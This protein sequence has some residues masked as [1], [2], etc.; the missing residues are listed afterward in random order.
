MKYALLMLALLPFLVKAGFKFKK[1][2][3]GGGGTGGTGGGPK[4]KFKKP[5]V[6]PTLVDV[7]VVCPQQKTL[8]K[9]S[10]NQTL[11]E[12]DM[13]AL[14]GKCTE[15]VDLVG[16]R[17]RETVKSSVNSM[18]VLFCTGRRH[19][20]VTYSCDVGDT[21]EEGRTM[22]C[23]GLTIP[24]KKLF[25]ACSCKKDCMLLDEHGVQV[26]NPYCVALG[27]ESPITIITLHKKKTMKDKFK[28]LMKK[29]AAYAASEEGRSQLWGAA[30]SVG[31]VMWNNRGMIKSVCQRMG[32]SADKCS[33]VNSLV[34]G[35]N[36]GFAVMDDGETMPL[37]D[38]VALASYQLPP[39]TGEPSRELLQSI[40]IEMNKDK[41]AHPFN[42]SNWIAELS[43]GSGALLLAV[44]AIIV[45][46][47]AM[48]R[49]SR[50]ERRRKK[51]K[52]DS[53]NEDE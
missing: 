16:D 19:V 1:P 18:E 28:S 25:D 13:K 50:R 22:H 23:E 37:P 53:V 8:N 42:I 35:P 14:K 38:S 46:V 10:V 20:T 5:V 9:A 7:S 36:G 30:K 31:A 34:N 11:T 6:V 49:K 33:T 45:T 29:G 41:V 44:I 2:T 48:K 24:A 21:K 40:L 15:C 47:I 39:V 4:L 3:F 26:S 43:G 52:D 27:F 17:G 12:Y 51:K 32:I